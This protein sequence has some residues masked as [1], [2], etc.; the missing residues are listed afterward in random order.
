[1]IQS[2]N[3]TNYLLYYRYLWPLLRAA[4]SRFPALFSSSFFFILFYGAAAVVVK[5]DENNNK[6]MRNHLIIT[7]C[8]TEKNLYLSVYG[9]A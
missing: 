4:N 7:C 5:V 3:V 9:S 6:K 1:M 2:S 8:W